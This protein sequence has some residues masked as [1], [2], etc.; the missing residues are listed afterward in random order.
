MIRLQNFPS[1]PPIRIPSYYYPKPLYLHP[2]SEGEEGYTFT[3]TMRE[4]RELGIVELK[5]DKWGG[6][7]LSLILEGGTAS[8]RIHEDEIR[9]K[10]LFRN[11]VGSLFSLSPLPHILQKEYL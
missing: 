8:F 10:E 11:K 1:L 6:Y 9:S 5:K 2:L 4:D 3:L 7:E